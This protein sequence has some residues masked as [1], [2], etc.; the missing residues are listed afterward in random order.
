MSIL[1]DDLSRLA[2]SINTQYSIYTNAKA[3][4][5]CAMLRMGS[6]LSRARILLRY[7]GWEKWVTQHCP[8]SIR[9]A[10][11][12]I[13]AAERF[14]DLV[15]RIEAID[16]DIVEQ[17]N[18]D[19]SD[20][21][22]RIDQLPRTLFYYASDV[23]PEEFL[24]SLD[25]DPESSIV[26][27]AAEIAT[28]LILNTSPGS[29]IEKGDVRSVVEVV[30]G[31]LATGALND[32]DGNAMPMAA[33]LRS[34]VIETTYERMMRQAEHIRVS[35]AAQRADRVSLAL[36][37]L[38]TAARRLRDA[39]IEAHGADAVLA[40]AKLLQQDAVCEKVG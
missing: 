23:S 20:L 5:I 27:K 2:T 26:G 39:L 22:N 10:R 7:N 18:A 21:I 8:F 37:D 1:T 15:S 19:D 16:Q 12:F 34:D 17:L 40:F 6:A 32:E 11:N 14:P 4:G 13:S 31:A 28:S 36:D 30:A 33:A 38:P 24:S 25:S 9:T 29:H 3:T 35:R